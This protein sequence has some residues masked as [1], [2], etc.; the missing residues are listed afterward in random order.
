VKPSPKRRD[1]VVATSIGTLGGILIGYSDLAL[2][3]L[4]TIFSFSVGG[5]VAYFA[6]CH[7]FKFGILALGMAN[8]IFVVIK[9]IR[10]PDILGMAPGEG[11]LAVVF[12][13]IFTVVPGLLGSVVFAALGW[14]KDS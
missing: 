9:L 3:C 11:L 5:G 4:G 13:A 12:L 2:V 14:S 6:S 1:W 8:V 7:K 10:R